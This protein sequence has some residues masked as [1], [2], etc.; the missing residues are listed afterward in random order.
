MKNIALLYLLA[1]ALIGC[2]NNSVQYNSSKV[3][4]ISFTCDRGDPIQ[5]RFLQNKELAIL[6]RNGKT[7]ELR[8]EPSGSGFSYSNGQ[9]SIRGKGKELM[10]L[11]GRM[12][13]INCTEQ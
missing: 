4:E 12:A 7:I 10:V 11:I 1:L 9:T 6:I 8:Q 2:S 13:P 5:V 3:N